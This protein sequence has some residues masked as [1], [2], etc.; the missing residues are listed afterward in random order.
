MQRRILSIV[1]IMMLVAISM[2]AAD[3]KYKIGDTGPGGGIVF[4]VNDK[5]FYVYE[6]DGSSKIYHYLETSYLLGEASW[7]PWDFHKELNNYG[8]CCENITPQTGIGYG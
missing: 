8:D 2:W 7:C 4:Y 1:I 6:S 3:K 5:G